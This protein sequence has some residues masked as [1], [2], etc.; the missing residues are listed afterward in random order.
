MREVL[1]SIGSPDVNVYY[2]FGEASL[3]A[4]LASVRSSGYAEIMWVT[5]SSLISRG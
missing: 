3:S 5:M 4:K 2:I 1:E